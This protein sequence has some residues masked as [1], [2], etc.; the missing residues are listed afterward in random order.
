MVSTVRNFW[1]MITDRKCGVIVMC[2]DL[3]KS[4]EVGPNTN[5]VDQ[6]HTRLYGIMYETNKLKRD[7]IID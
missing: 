3:I 2:S 1:K 4:G 5:V 7:K 6:F